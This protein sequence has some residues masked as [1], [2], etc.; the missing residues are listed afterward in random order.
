VEVK[1]SCVFVERNKT[2]RYAYHFIHKCCVLHIYLTIAVCNGRYLPQLLRRRVH[3]AVQAR[4]RETFQVSKESVRY[5]NK[6]IEQIH[7]QLFIQPIFGA[8][9]FINFHILT[10][11]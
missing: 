10:V 4:K 6:I 11:V 2:F 1:V 9:Q 3:G 7:D 5:V 8:K